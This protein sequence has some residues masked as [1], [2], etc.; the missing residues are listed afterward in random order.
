[1][2]RE[3][4]DQIPVTVVRLE[5]CGEGAWRVRLDLHPCTDYIRGKI[6]RQRTLAV[7]PEEMFAGK[8]IPLPTGPLIPPLPVSTSLEMHQCTESHAGYN[9]RVVGNIAERRSKILFP[10]EIIVGVQAAIAVSA[11][12]P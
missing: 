4:A 3:P 1:M 6:E 5:H 2:F 9:K 8:E 7:R 11:S 10:V 12:D